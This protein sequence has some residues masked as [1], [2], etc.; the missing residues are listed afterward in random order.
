MLFLA[1]LMTVSL[2]WN[3][4]YVLPR[5]DPGALRERAGGSRPDAHA[6]SSSILASSSWAFQQEGDWRPP[7]YSTHRCLGGKFDDEWVTS[8][9]KF[10]NVCLNSSTLEIEYYADPDLPEVPVVYDQVKARPLL[11]FPVNFT[12][13]SPLEEATLWWRPVVKRRSF[14]QEG[15][16]VKWAPASQALLQAFH[17][18]FL[19]NFGHVMYDLLT[20]LFT[21]Q[22]LFG[23]Y[24]P[25]AQPLILHQLG[26]YTDY[27]WRL[28]LLVNTP[29]PAKSLLR[30]T[31]D[32]YATTLANYTRDVLGEGNE[33][34]VCFKTLLAGSYSLPRRLERSGALAYRQ[35]AVTRLGLEEPPQEWK[36]RIENIKE[37]AGIL[38]RRYP[39]AR[40]DVI[41]FTRHPKFTIPQQARAEEAMSFPPSLLTRDEALS[42]GRMSLKQGPAGLQQQ[43]QQGPAGMVEM[44][45][46]TSILVSPCGGIATV[47]AF[48]RP[49]ST[50][51]VMNYW[52]TVLKRSVNMENAFYS[53]L[54]YVDVQY[55][56]VTLQDYKGTSD[57]PGCFNSFV[58]NDDRGYMVECNLR[59]KGDSLLRLL[60]Y[61]DNAM[62]RWA[63]RTGRYEVLSSLKKSS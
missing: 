22:H 37:I 31:W 51:I 39:L 41:N 4:S 63:A 6:A 3:Q 24:T 14:P 10:D 42:Q 38:R 56:P 44:M 17:G 23:I 33:G 49:E 15:R 47:L 59:L 43:Q 62:L 8:T 46:N 5:Q 26:N 12:N 27:D 16:H 20:P 60:H 21:M 52:D 45:S 28:Q 2:L 11:Q 25:D 32:H 9:C 29:N 35:V 36:R 34:L 7:K 55:F 30:L 57:R 53:K 1:T 19:Y 61:V 40:V 58:R 13:P 54:D 18:R 48:M 50:A